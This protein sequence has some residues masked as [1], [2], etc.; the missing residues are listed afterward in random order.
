MTT[1]LAVIEEVFRRFKESRIFLCRDVLLPDYIPEALP[2]REEQLR[3]LALILA[4]ALRGSK[5]SNVIVYGPTGTGKTVCVLLVLRKLV[6][7]SRGGV[8]SLYVNCRQ[9]DTSYRVLTELC[10]QLGLH[11]PNSGLSTGEVLRRFSDGIE[12]YGKVAIVVLDEVDVLVKRSGDAVLY[13]LTRLNTSLSKGKVSI[14][15]ISNDLRFTELLDPRVRSSLGEE[16]I[17]FPPYNYAELCD[18]LRERARLA[19]KPGVVSD[20]VISLC[21]AIAARE[22]GDARK[23]LDLLRVAGEIAEREGCEQVTE[24]HVKKALV[25]LERDRVSEL[26]RGMPF[27]MKLVLLAIYVA[28]KRYP[29][30]VT[31]GDVYS[32]YCE[33]CSCIGVTPLTQRRVSDILA[34]LELLGLVEAKVVNLGRYGRTRRVKLI[35]GDEH[36]LKALEEEPQ[37]RPLISSLRQSLSSG[38]TSAVVK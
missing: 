15:G 36:L 12:E 35:V 5:P 18:I 33:V 23:A 3:K 26:L 1:A 19:F 25:Q 30:T 7:E 22:H 20:S 8:I 27:H 34:Q 24:E 38:V 32:T 9:Y 37:L 4:P 2:H 16:T 17:V 13:H 21:A 6:E 28:T 29:L 31:T 14:I 10:R 11:V